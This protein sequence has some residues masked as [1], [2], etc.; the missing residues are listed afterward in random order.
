MSKTPRSP[1]IHDGIEDPRSSPAQGMLIGHL[2][3]RRPFKK[4]DWPEGSDLIVA[5]TAASYQ[6][7]ILL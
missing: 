4:P 3:S 7:F 1:S 5:A 2:I 6:S